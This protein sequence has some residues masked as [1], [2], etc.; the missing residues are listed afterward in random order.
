M[1]EPIENVPDYTLV[2]LFEDMIMA[3][4]G[5]FVAYAKSMPYSYEQIRHELFN[6]LEH[7]QKLI[8]ELQRS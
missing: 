5:M 2:Y 6:R 4:Q 7:R 8:E 3:R 1:P